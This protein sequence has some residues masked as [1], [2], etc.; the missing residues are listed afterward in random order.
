[1]LV[2]GKEMLVEL[3]T[4]SLPVADPDQFPAWICKDW[5]SVRMKTLGREFEMLD[6]KSVPEKNISTKGPWMWKR[7]KA[8]G[9]GGSR[10]WDG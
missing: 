9:E 5:G 2:G 1:M 7:L 6:K 8:G 4:L 3:V 10:G